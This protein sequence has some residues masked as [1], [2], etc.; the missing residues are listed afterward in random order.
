MVYTSYANTKVH[1]IVWSLQ[2]CKAVP[3][4]VS[5]VCSLYE[6]KL[7]LLR[8]VECNELYRT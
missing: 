1:D 5:G 4:A 6:G 2:K 7:S 3:R 8:R